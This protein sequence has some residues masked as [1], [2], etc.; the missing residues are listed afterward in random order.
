MKETIKKYPLFPYALSLFFV[1]HGFTENSDIVPPKD[2]VLLF[3]KYAGF[4]I[5]LT[6]LFWLVYK[7]F[8]KAGLVVFFIMMYNFFFSIVHDF[9]NKNFSDT[10]LTKYSFILPAS[11]IGFIILIIYIRKTNKKFITT[12]KYL[13][14]L[15]IILILIDIVNLAIKSIRESAPPDVVLSKEFTNCD[16]CSKPDIYLILTDEYAGKTQLQ[17]I[18][19]FDNSTFLNELK[20]R[21]YHIV[22]ESRGNYN[23]THYAM[24]SMFNMDYLT[25]I[26]GEHSSHNDLSISYNTLKKSKTLGF[27]LNQGY[28]FYNYSVF[29]FNGQPS[30]ATS[31]FI[32]G[33][34]L[35]ITAQTF[36][37][38]I[39]RD[40]GFHLITT[41]KLKWVMSKFYY[42]PLTN[43][44]KVY[45]LTKKI[46]AKKTTTPKFVYTHLIMPHYRYYYNSKGQPAPFEKI[47][48]DSYC[49][50]KNAYIEYLQYTNGKLLSLI[51]QIK[52]SSEKPPVI[53]LMSDH[54]YR[55]F[56][57]PEDIKQVDKK[58]YFM[59]LNAINFPNGNY[60]LFY[61]SMSNVN[62][63]RVILNSL[64]HQKLSILKDSTIFLAQ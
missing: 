20:T 9:F 58:Y 55:Q 52:K 54:G 14:W 3:L 8:I 5:V 29:D 40:L 37:H 21:G 1:L 23:F 17:D 27:L 59:S 39:R 28:S 41:L 46:A 53:I 57:S 60:S 64:F 34:T 6:L 62:Q 10:F 56:L 51:D 16:T 43:T 61:D 63:F 4:S 15:F 35:P 30:V 33:K 44:E 45:E 18:F 11:I 26:T 50:D 42:E 22:P 48:D 49:I 32:P 25:G 36:I 7:S 47:I 12:T 2:A 38:R 24:A 19:G 31:P 13:N